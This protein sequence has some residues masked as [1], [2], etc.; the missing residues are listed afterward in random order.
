MNKL[1]HKLL[2]LTLI[3]ALPSLGCFSYYTIDK[4]NAGANA[5]LPALAILLAY[6]ALLISLA[7]FIVLRVST[8]PSR[9]GSWLAAICLIT[10]GAILLI[11]RD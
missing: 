6:P 7:S 10:S 4:V 8:R 1:I 11:A 2:I 9:L 5:K 3:I